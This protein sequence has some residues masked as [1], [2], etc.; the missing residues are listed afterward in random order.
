MALA[1]STGT[2][3]VHLVRRANGLEPFER[4]LASHRAH[5]AG[6][7]HELVLLFKGFADADELTPYRRQAAGLSA[8][9]LFV[10]DRGLD[11]AAYG[12]AARALPHPRLCFLNSYSTILVSGWL[13]LLAR[14]LETHGA[15][16]TGAT[17]SWGSHRSFAL[18]LLRLPNGYRG[19]LGSRAAM[20]TALAGAADSGAGGSGASGERRSLGRLIE[21]VGGLGNEIVG[22]RGFPAPHVRTNAF[23]VERGLLLSLRSGRLG[24]KAANYRLEAGSSSLT[25]QLRR[26][27]L[28]SLIVGRDGEPLAP[29]QW[30]E[31]EIYWQGAQRDL[32][33]ADNQTRAYDRASEADRQA[34]A[35]YA[36]G[37]R[38]WSS[39]TGRSSTVGA[40]R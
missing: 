33:V 34:L 2:A 3:I 6:E 30:P 5:E 20:G 23:L 38:G 11:L 15:G 31:R 35:R 19:S 9:E 21:T 12:A 7:P 37:S 13:A 24:S 8:H 39:E 22:H 14:G 26:R 36:W 10:D 4:F 1:V 25:E 17:G 27:G 28:A 18:W 16:V 29:E 40:A 32:L